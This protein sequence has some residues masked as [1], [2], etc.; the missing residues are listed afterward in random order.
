MIG[1]YSEKKNWR[2]ENMSKIAIV[3]DSTA[4]VPEELRQHPN[5]YIIPIPVIINNQAVVDT[6]VDAND[7]YNSLNQS[8]SLPTTSQ[9]SMGEVMELYQ[10]L[11]DKGYDKVISIHLSS[12]ISGFIN[13]L[14][15]LAKEIGNIQVYP[16][17]SLLTSAPMCDM[18]SQA[19]E[20][21]D[22]NKDVDEILDVLVDMRNHQRAYIVVDDLHH[23]VRGGR[24]TNGSALLGSLLHIKP[25]LY[26]DEEG[27]ISVYDKIRSSKKAYRKCMELIEEEFNYLNKKAKVTIA[28][29]NYED[30][31]KELAEVLSKK[32]DT[33]V[34]IKDLGVVVGTHLGANSIGFAIT[35]QE[36]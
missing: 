7:F 9:P 11:S 15:N 19:L 6:N 25:V 26:F 8:E 29:T 20:M 10:Q 4:V 17:D 2:V 18:V 23:L 32:L 35:K 3:T 30:K 13:H 28:H 5:L 33:E 14:T 34:H 31:A 12:G 24:L 1:Y 36:D 21:V 16:F 27:K 22:Q